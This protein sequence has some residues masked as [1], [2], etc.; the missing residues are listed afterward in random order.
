MRSFVKDDN[1]FWLK[2]SKLLSLKDDLF[3]C[4]IDVVGIFADFPHN[5]GLAA[6]KNYLGK[7]NNKTVSSESLIKLAVRSQQLVWASWKIFRTEKTHSHK[8]KD[9]STIGL[10]DTTV[11]L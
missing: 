5:D 3:L 6:I 9:W 7:R 4:L 2:L 8:H 1:N 10:E 11:S